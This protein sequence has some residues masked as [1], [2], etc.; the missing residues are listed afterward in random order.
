MDQ[1]RLRMNGD[2]IEFIIYSSRQQLK[3]CAINNINVTGEIVD[4]TD[5]TKYLGAWLDAIFVT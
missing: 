4:K 3:K 1:N 2:K 5:C